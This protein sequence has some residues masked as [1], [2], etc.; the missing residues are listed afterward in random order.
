MTGTGQCITLTVQLDD[1]TALV[2]VPGDFPILVY[3]AYSKQGTYKPTAQGQ[4]NC[5]GTESAMLWVDDPA[6]ASTYLSSAVRPGGGVVVQEEC[7]AIY[8]ASC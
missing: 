6:I 4:G 7:S 3:H 1:G 8:L 2:H 5:S